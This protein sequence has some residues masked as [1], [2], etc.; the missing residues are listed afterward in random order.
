ME[1]VS[2]GN[3]KFI[4]LLG[5]AAG[6]INELI[7]GPYYCQNV[8]E[9]NIQGILDTAYYKSDFR[10][11]LELRPGYSDNIHPDTP[12]CIIKVTTSIISTENTWHLEN[13]NVLDSLVITRSMFG[14]LNNFSN[15]SLVRYDLFCDSCSQ[16]TPTPPQYYPPGYSLKSSE[17]SDIEKFLMMRD[18]IEFKVKWLGKPN[19]LLSIDKIT[20][21]DQKGFEI[22]DPT[23]DARNRIELQANSLSTFN[24]NITGW[25]GIDEPNSIDKYAPIK[26]V[27]EI[28]N[29]YSNSTRPLWLSIMGK[30]DGVWEN[31]DNPFGTYHLSPWKEMKKR[32]GNINIWQDVYYLDY[33][34][35]STVCTN[36]T[37]PWYSENI[38]I[39]AELN[40]K[41]AYDL[42]NYFGASIQCGEIHIDGIAEQRDI[43][44]S[45]LLYETNLALMY[46]TKFLSLYTYF[47]QVDTSDTSNIGTKHAIIDSDHGNLI[48]TLKYNMLR[49]KINPRLKGLMGKTLKKL[50]LTCPL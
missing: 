4:R 18:Y 48:Y 24:N 14:Q 11:K 7:C 23:S 22:M 19:Y 6:S 47:S 30:W 42:D 10:M 38:K 28:L 8:Y 25:L 39:A 27:N 49:D 20:V 46:G 31:S 12:L 2:Q 29:N 50:A 13:T 36:C 21:Y 34:W 15:L 3:D 40:Y 45:D 17:L 43:T 33:P 26:K 35:N 41:Q 1:E 32:I 37:E 9:Q 44:P 16:T 5:S